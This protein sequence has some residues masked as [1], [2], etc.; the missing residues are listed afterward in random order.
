MSACVSISQ[1]VAAPLA[2]VCG[3]GRLPFAVADA[4]RRRGRRV[5]LFPLRGWADPAAVAD[6]PHHWI[7]LGQ[8]G[9]MIGRVRAEGCSEIAFVGSVLRPSIRQLRFDL[10]TLRLLPRIVRAYKGGD[11]HLLSALG[12]LLEEFGIRVVGAHE[13]APEILIPQGV[14]GRHRPSPRDQADIARGFEIL[15]AIGPFDVGQAAVIA[16]LR[17]LAIEGAEGTD[18]MLKRVAL[19]RQSGRVSMP[20]QTGVVVKAAKPG[21]DR[22]FDLPS[23]GVQTIEAAAS[24]GLAG[25]AVEAA[26]AITAELKDMARAADATGLFLVG[27]SPP[28]GM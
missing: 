4:A 24:A 26:G 14:L 3:G 1:S 19:M 6:F 28:P 17:V 5:V 25:V 15:A 27:V 13:V 23:V 21:Q 2:I 11:N 9:R 16:G 20:P 22:R 18:E 7:E 8:A 10:L 12:Q